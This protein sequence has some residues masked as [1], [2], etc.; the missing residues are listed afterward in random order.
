MIDLGNRI[1]SSEERDFYVWI[2]PQDFF[3]QASIKSSGQFTSAEL[4]DPDHTLP[5][6]RDTEHGGLVS[7]FMKNVTHNYGVEFN[8]EHRRAAEFID[9]PCRMV[10]TFLFLDEETAQ[11]YSDRN[12][13]HVGNRLLQR[14]KSV[15]DYVYSV[16]DS[17]WIDYLRIPHFWTTEKLRPLLEI[18]GRAFRQ[19]ITY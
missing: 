3:V 14:V 4:I 2:N 17:S 5:F 13:D 11:Q 19:K 9:Y 10:A 7:P 16:H 6:V 18:T 1:A 8:L 12:P 15:G